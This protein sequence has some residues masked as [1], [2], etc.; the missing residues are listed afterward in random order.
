MGPHPGSATTPPV[1]RQY[2]LSDQRAKYPMDAEHPIERYDH[3]SIPYH[4]NYSHRDSHHYASQHDWSDPHAHIVSESPSR[5]FSPG[6]IRMQHARS[7]S[8]RT[9]DEIHLNQDTRRYSSCD[10]CHSRL[11]YTN[12]SFHTRHSRYRYDEH[13]DSHLSHYHHLI[14]ME[15]M[16]RHSTSYMSQ[17]YTSDPDPSHNLIQSSCREYSGDGRHYRQC[18]PRSPERDR[19]EL[20]NQ[21]STH[22]RT[23]NYYHSTP[24]QGIEISDFYLKDASE[25]SLQRSV[26]L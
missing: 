1:L 19:Y 21:T 18:G 17:R 24:H 20:Q 9:L 2:E 5:D 26:P 23:S 14:P 4:E 3:T 7:R 13:I 11:H 15:K 25:W 6:Y 8:N 12:P 22:G 10:R 16:D